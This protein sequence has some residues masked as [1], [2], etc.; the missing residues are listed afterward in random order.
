MAGTRGRLGSS[1]PQSKQNVTG[2]VVNQEGAA[3][4]VETS[5]QRAEGSGEGGGWKIAGS[6]KH[7][8]IYVKEVRKIVVWH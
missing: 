8:N 3:G 4:E 6:P 5:D 1:A 2:N 7:A